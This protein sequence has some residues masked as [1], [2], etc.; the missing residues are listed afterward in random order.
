MEDF[1]PLTS[2]YMRIGNLLIIK[3]L[4]SSIVTPEIF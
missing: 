3:Y 4:R 1:L 2:K